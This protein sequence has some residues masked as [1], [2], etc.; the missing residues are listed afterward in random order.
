M[1]EL[2]IIEGFKGFDGVNGLPETGQITDD[3]IERL[4]IATGA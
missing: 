2:H 4:E 3:L 1:T